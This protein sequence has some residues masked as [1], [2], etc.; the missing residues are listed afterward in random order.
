MHR[1]FTTLQTPYQVYEAEVQEDLAKAVTDVDRQQNLPL[2][3]TEQ[4]P[5][6]DFS[7]A[8]ITLAAVACALLLAGRALL[9]RN[10]A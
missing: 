1:F 9:L 6:A 3:Y 5:R 10:W 4:L 7:R 2:E 8:F